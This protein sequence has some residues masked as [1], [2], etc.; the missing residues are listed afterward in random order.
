VA[1]L[2]REVL[3]QPQIAICMLPLP[4]GSAQDGQRDLD[5]A[6]EDQANARSEAT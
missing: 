5:L 6:G 2:L 3:A 1:S 4:F